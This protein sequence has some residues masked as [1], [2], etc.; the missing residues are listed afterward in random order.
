MAE[1]LQGIEDPSNK[2]QIRGRQA[3]VDRV[4]W[5]LRKHRT[6]LYQRHDELRHGPQGEARS[7]AV[8]Q[9]LAK[10][11]LDLI[12]PDKNFENLRLKAADEDLIELTES[13]KYEGIKVPITVIPIPGDAPG[14]YVRAGFRRLEVVRRLGWQAIPAIVLPADT[15]T[16]EEYWTNIIENS[17]RSRLSTYEIASAARTMRCKFKIKVSE[18][19][20]RA[21]YSETY[22][23]NL[24]RCLDNLPEEVVEVWKDKAPIPVSLYLSWSNMTRD[25]AVKM[26]LAY[27][28]KHPQVAREWQ[29]PA[30]TR[31]KVTPIRM[32]STRGLMRMQRVRFAVEVAQSIDEKTRSLCLKLVDYCSGARDDVPTIYD[33]NRKLHSYKSRRRQDLVMP[34]P[35]EDVPDPDEKERE[36]DLPPVVRLKKSK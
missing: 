18:F 4:R 6:E 22:V 15:P 35:D 23:A 28:G 2:A 36:G 17:A 34:V 1:I 33:P 29:P 30:T 14:F 9:Q 26:M 7:L 31:E 27:R 19:S 12:L 20:R 32:A 5:E 16:I 3:I 21:G 8:A 10:I 24:L 11:P 13:I 25:E